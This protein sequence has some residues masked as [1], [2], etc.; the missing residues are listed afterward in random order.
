MNKL[1]HLTDEQMYDLIDPKLNQ[2]PNADSH[3][4][5]LDCADC[6][7]ELS[8]LRASVVNF[9]AAATNLAAAESPALAS[10]SMSSSL[11]THTSRPRIWAAS[12]AMATVLLAV[13]VSVIHPRATP[14]KTDGVAAA[15]APQVVPATAESDEALLDGIQRDLSTPIPPSL[16]PLAVPAAS[17]DISTQD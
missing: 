10:R 9:R 6:S 2:A 16:E 1:N 8:S 3:L 7:A 12:L 15:V 5:L 17:S 11:R 14:P 4:H 13:S